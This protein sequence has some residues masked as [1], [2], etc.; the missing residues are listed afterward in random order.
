MVSM[1]NKKN[2]SLIIIKYSSYLELCSQYLLSYICSSAVS[3][4][5]FI[6]FFSE[7]LQDYFK[8]VMAGFAG[9]PQMISATLLALTRIMYEFKGDLFN[10]LTL[11]RSSCIQAS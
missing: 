5:L 4:F 1:R 2:Y 7:G 6:F 11:Q 8:M 10:S 3:Q 9:S